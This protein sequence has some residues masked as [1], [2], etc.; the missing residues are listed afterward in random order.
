[1]NFKTVGCVRISYS[2]LINQ[3]Y[4]CLSSTHPFVY[5]LCIFFKHAD[6]AECHMDANKVTIYETGQVVD[7]ITLHKE[8]DSDG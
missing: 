1:M 4:L 8:N 6:M 2:S 5:K 3:I 7:P